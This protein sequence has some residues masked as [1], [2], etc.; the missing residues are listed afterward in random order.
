MARI[1]LF[2][3]LYSTSKFYT[4]TLSQPT[5]V[6]YECDNNKGNYTTNSTYQ[7]N[8]NRLL[9]SLPSDTN[10]NYGFYNSSYGQNSDQVNAIGL[11]RGDIN[12]DACRNCLNYSSNSIT[13]LCPNQKEAIEWYDEC[14]LRYSH[15]SIF[16]VVE[17]SP[18][19]LLVNA[20]NITSNVDGFNEELMNLFDKL[21]SKAAGGDS[22]RKYAA[23]SAGFAPNFLTIYALVQCTP[24][25]SKIECENCLGDAFSA[26]S[27]CC[28]GKR[29]G[30]AIYPSCKIRYE[31]NQ[32]YQSTDDD[33]GAPPPSPS[34]NSTTT[35]KGMNAHVFNFNIWLFI[36]G[37]RRR[38]IFF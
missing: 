33:I 19:R 8:I 11:C 14:M 29:G 1:M 4:Q 34:P 6:S 9:S 26:I 12:P 16:G 23:G 3:F 10:N 22:L 28:I 7:V 30:Q 32:F 38:W 2:L 31:L 35:S 15:R 36:F 37:L 24:D 17:T 21:R 18:S 5:F 13:E 27:Q 20:Q 25:L